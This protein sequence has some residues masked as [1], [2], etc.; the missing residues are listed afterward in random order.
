MEDF[1]PAN[2]ESRQKLEA[3]VARLS[4]ADL[5]L[6]N[7]VEWTVAAIFAHLAFW[8]QRALLLVRR[9]KETGVQF[10]PIDVDT[11]NDVVLPFLLA[12]PP[13]KAC[14]IVLEIAKTLDGELAALPP[15]FVNDILVNG[16]NLHL[17][18]ANHRQLHMAE[19]EGLLKEQ[20]NG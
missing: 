14:Q 13:R 12:V 9:W 5:L 2:E 19:I 10:S 6:V 16:K 18:R 1:V 7:D 17:N 20:N 11:I 15:A 3:L 4:D 8:D